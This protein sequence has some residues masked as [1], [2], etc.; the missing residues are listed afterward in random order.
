MAE[1]IENQPYIR[2]VSE[3]ATHRR[4]I[5]DHNCQNRVTGEYRY[6]GR[7]NSAP[8]K[9]GG[10][11]HEHALIWLSS[12][13]SWLS[14]FGQLGGLNGEFVKVAMRIAESGYPLPE[15]ASPGSNPTGAG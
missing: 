6:R 13:D 4:P 12:M 2:N 14:V 3:T 15:H 1:S 9:R 11:S 10:R 5:T 7:R 8:L